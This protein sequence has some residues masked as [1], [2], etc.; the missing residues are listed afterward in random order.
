LR[1]KYFAVTHL[2]KETQPKRDAVP[3]VKHYASF[4]DVYQNK[5]MEGDK[6]SILDLIKKGEPVLAVNYVVRPSKYSE[7]NYAS[8]QLQIDGKPHYTETGS[9][10]VI[11]RLSRVKDNLPLMLRFTTKQ[12]RSGRAYETIE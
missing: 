2:P 9:Q 5:R 12:G 7:S 1:Q 11:D 3:Q 4:A 6:V 8:I 10:S